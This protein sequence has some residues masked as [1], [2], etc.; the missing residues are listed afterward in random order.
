MRYA[1]LFFGHL[2]CITCCVELSG[3]VMYV[4]VTSRKYLHRFSFRTG[5]HVWNMKRIHLRT[6]LVLSMLGGCGWC[7]TDGR[8]VVR[9]THLV[10]PRA[11]DHGVTVP[12]VRRRGALLPGRGPR[13]APALLLDPRRAVRV[14]LVAHA[15]G[16]AHRQVGVRSLK[17]K[18][19]SERAAHHSHTRSMSKWP[20]Y[21]IA[22]AFHYNK[23]TC[24]IYDIDARLAR[25]LARARGYIDSSFIHSDSSSSSSSSLL[26]VLG[27]S[28]VCYRA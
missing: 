26:S 20:A 22:I 2:Q 5:S 15:V 12:R 9:E 14:D 27:A 16:T 13:G 21:R 7:S 23:S 10:K 19:Q 24:P 6:V 28:S 3:Y 8:T 18:G 11:V 4:H 25:S 1:T 17:W